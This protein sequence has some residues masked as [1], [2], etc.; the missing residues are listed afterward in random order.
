MLEGSPLKTY[1]V[2]SSHCCVCRLLVF[3]H[4][5]QTKTGGVLKDEKRVVISLGM[6]GQ[7][8]INTTSVSTC[9]EG[10]CQHQHYYIPSLPS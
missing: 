6:E 5:A 3:S 10:S 1:Q 2:R 8:P 4:H 9:A 7:Q